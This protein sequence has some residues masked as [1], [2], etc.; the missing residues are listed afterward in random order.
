MVRGLKRGGR[1]LSAYCGETGVK[2]SEVSASAAFDVSAGPR[3]PGIHRS[4]GRP[5]G[6]LRGASA[7]LYSATRT[8]KGEVVDGN[9]GPVSVH[10]ALTVVERALSAIVL[11]QKGQGLESD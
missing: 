7:W 10:G 8:N 4:A 3:P 9:A 2:M 11:H 1:A 5:S 6:A